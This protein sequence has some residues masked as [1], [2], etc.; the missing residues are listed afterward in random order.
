MKTDVNTTWA[1]AMTARPVTG[2]DGLLTIAL[3]EG[4]AYRVLPKITGF[5]GIISALFKKLC[6]EAEMHET[7]EADDNFEI[8]ASTIKAIYDQTCRS[9]G[10]TIGSLS[11]CRKTVNKSARCALIAEWATRLPNKSCCVPTNV[12]QRTKALSQKRD[13]RTRLP[14]LASIGTTTRGGAPRIGLPRQVPGAGKGNLGASGQDCGASGRT[15]V[16]SG[17]SA[18]LFCP[19]VLLSSSTEDDSLELLCQK[20]I[21]IVLLPS[22]ANACQS[23]PSPQQVPPE[24]P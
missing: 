22:C 17:G 6:D 2:T 12:S 16:I 11:T 15:S 13:R 7:L 23:E 19:Q 5:F 10:L 8:V 24:L 9:C 20:A 21:C 1:E 18:N 14:T 4:D 3:G